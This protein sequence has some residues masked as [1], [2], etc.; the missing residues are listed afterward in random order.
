MLTLLNKQIQK[1][2]LCKVVNQGVG[3]QK[4]Q[5]SVNVVCERFLKVAA[6]AMKEI[7]NGTEVPTDDKNDEKT[8]ENDEKKEEV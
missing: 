7:K 2:L 3:G 4:G 1:I 8:G 5:K 6:A